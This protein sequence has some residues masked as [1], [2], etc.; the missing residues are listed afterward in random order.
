MLG[1]SSSP[2][3]SLLAAP[4]AAL[5]VAILA[6]QGVPTP[7][8]S[9]TTIRPFEVHLPD[10]A[11][12]DLRRRIAATRWPDKE[13]V[14]DQSQ[15]AQLVSLQEL[16]GYW[17]NSYDWRKAEAKLNDLPQFKTSIDNVDIHFIHVR[18]RHNSAAR[19]WFLA[20]FDSPHRRSLQ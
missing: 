15:V 18:S 2:S 4:A 12:V 20:F 17:G 5:G 8:A 14:A 10:A 16:V 6:A 7:A 3:R 9:E 19:N 11:L 1:E 13:T